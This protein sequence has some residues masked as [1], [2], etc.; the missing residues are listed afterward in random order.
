MTLHRRFKP[1][2]PLTA[3]MRV[4][5]G[6]HSGEAI[7]RADTSLRAMRE[8]C[9]ASIDALLDRLDVLAKPAQQSAAGIEQLYRSS[10]DILDLCG[11]AG[12]V[13][14]DAAARS[15][16]DYLDRIAEGER[17]DLRGVNVHVSAMR[18]LHRTPASGAERSAVLAGL[19][20]LTALQARPATGGVQ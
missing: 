16:C 11:P 7:R 20:Q 15:L 18:M 6:I 3:K 17:L 8:G 10:S 14:L 2:L 12:Q 19:G 9:L 5:G 13:G 1:V 4:K